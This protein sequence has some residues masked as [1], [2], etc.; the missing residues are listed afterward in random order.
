MKKQI[1]EIKRMQ[2][3]AGILKEN[4]Y[5]PRYSEEDASKLFDYH[6]RTGMLPEDMTEEEFDELMSYYGI[7]RDNDE[8]FID[9]AGGSGIHSHI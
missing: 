6:E 5:I 2:Q 7:K 4:Q 9:P 1:N 8:D 3:L